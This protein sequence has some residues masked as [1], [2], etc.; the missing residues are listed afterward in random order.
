MH[1]VPAERIFRPH[2]WGLFG[3]SDP[4]A[5]DYRACQTFG[6]LYG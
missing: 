4:E 6:A 2:A 5:A 3:T 1:N